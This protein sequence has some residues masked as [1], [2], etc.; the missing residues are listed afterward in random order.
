MKILIVDRDVPGDSGSRNLLAHFSD[1]SFSLSHVHLLSDAIEHLS[2]DPFDIVLL[3]LDLPDSRGI[4][5]L[6]TLKMRAA[7][8]PVVV[9]TSETGEALAQQA[10]KEGA[11]DYLVREE[12]NS[13]YLFRTLRYAIE[14]HQLDQSARR[15]QDHF[16]LMV[17]DRATRLGLTNE[18][19]RKE[20][21]VRKRRERELKRSNRLLRVLTECNQAT[22]HAKNEQELLTWICEVMV[23][24]GGYPF[25]WI[26]YVD[27]GTDKRALTPV[28]DAGFASGTLE[29]AGIVCEDTEL[30]SG[31][32][33]IA[34]KTK[35]ACVFQNIRK[36]RRFPR[37]VEEAK[38][39][40]YGSAMGLPILKEPDLTPGGAIVLLSRSA[41]AFD[42]EEKKI[43]TQ[44]AEDLSFGIRALRTRDAHD[45]A[46]EA[47][48][49]SEMFYRTLI[50]TLPVGITVVDPDERIAF[51]SSKSSE[52]LRLPAMEE[53][54][55]TP[56]GKWLA[57][58]PREAPAKMFRRIQKASGKNLPTENNLQRY[59]GSTFWAELRSAALRDTTEEV[60]GTLV[61][62]QDITERRLAEE[63][64]QAA[65]NELEDRVEERTADLYA[66]NLELHKEMV[67]REQLM[68]ALS[69]SEQAMRN[70]QRLLD[71][72]EKLAH[73][74]SWERDISSG[75]FRWSDEL[76]CI[77]GYEPYEI[78]PTHALFTAAIHPDDRERVRGLEDEALAG[79]RDYD[80]VFRI[81]RP[82]GI[83]RFVYLRGEVMRDTGGS[84]VGIRGS[85]QDIT[86]RRKAEEEMARLATIVAQ[87]DDAIVG[88]HP[89]STVFSWNAGAGKIF[90]YS[91]ADAAGRP[92]TDLISPKRNT[93]IRHNLDQILAG[94]PVRTVESL[95]RKRDGSH[96]YATLTISPVKDENGAMFGAI[97]IARDT[98]GRK[99]I[100]NALRDSE[101]KYKSLFETMAQAAFTVD[102]RGNVLD[103]NPAAERLLLSSRDHLVGK[104]A[105][106]PEQKAVHRDG[107]VLPD[108]QYPWV[109][110]FREGKEVHDI[111]GLAGTSGPGHR[112]AIAY[113]TPN[114]R[115]GEHAPHQV[116]VILNDIT[117]IA[118]LEIP[119]AAHQRAAG[120]KPGS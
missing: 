100:Q 13:R 71:A 52:M 102:P 63:K 108:E 110:A 61:V 24:T 34:V 87:S 12:I 112:W 19:L 114:F 2:R 60:I 48:H 107:S 119:G 77:F 67:R 18:Q 85:A 9:L 90:G 72:A 73:I 21:E 93:R 58:D 49:D 26:G 86:E 55:G 105:L 45:A 47:L 4:K 6:H 51:L 53:G 69:D 17:A 39:L 70:K 5:T 33:S 91:P 10:L 65:Y 116:S 38:T 46:E 92:I 106:N 83:I 14:H 42:S 113:A 97:L 89:D 59:D 1:E 75:S 120:R 74:G 25:V 95:C 64:L 40:G 3:D 111:I 20:N 8:V 31:P 84:P 101:Q 96:F 117:D 82:D 29:R 99:R 98:T 109:R 37:L 22:G 35:K 36:D 66:A 27:P 50:N 76:Y 15:T 94:E 81:T 41:V 23:F 62:T 54:L 104:P 118:G 44:L 103:A 16:E 78:K 32:G 56:F 30:A 79:S 28:A 43:L 11:E 68:A 7:E 115:P 80:M 88:M 57:A